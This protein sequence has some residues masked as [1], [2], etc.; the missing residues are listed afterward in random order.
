M[1]IKQKMYL[2]IPIRLV[3]TGKMDND[4]FGGHTGKW[5]L[6]LEV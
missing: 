2:F 3:K 6:L 1:Q 4:K 5:A